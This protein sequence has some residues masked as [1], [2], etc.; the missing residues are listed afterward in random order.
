MRGAECWTDHCMIMAKVHMRVH[1][2]MW[3]HGPCGRC[4]DCT[5]LED[6]IARNEFQCSLAEKL[7][8]LQLIL[9]GENATDQQWTSISS[10]L[11]E[12]AAL[13]VGNK[14]KNHQDGFDNNS[15]TTH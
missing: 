2:P 5:R 6:I 4:L 13:T 10:A 7:G 9:S 3:K 14:S 15:D 1:T 11:R 12:A 8:E